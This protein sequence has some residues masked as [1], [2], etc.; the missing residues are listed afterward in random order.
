MKKTKTSK[1]PLLSSSD[2]LIDKALNAFDNVNLFPEKLARANAT[3]LRVGA[4]KEGIA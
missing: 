4:P 2:V 1:T 3:L